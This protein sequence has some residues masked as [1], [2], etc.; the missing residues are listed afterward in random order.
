MNAMNRLESLTVADI[1]SKPVISIGAHETMDE[2]AAKLVAHEISGAPVVDEQ[3][4]CVG[5]LTSSDYVRYKAEQHHGDAS[6]RGQEFRLDFGSDQVACCLHSFERNRVR[7]RMATGVQTI[8]PHVPLLTAA[9]QM[10]LAHIHHLMVL[11][12]T[13]RPA[14]MISTLDI[15]AAL[16]KAAEEAQGR[17]SAP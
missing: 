8:E 4:H 12:R 16:S 5:V 10:C 2:A 6:A 3:G 14:G 7:E 17:R 1:M 13:G 11:D 9:K 15:V